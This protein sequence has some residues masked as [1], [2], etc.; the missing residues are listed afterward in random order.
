M[1]KRSWGPAAPVAT[2]APGH[3]V[4]FIAR[5]RQLGALRERGLRVESPLGDVHLREVTATDDPAA[6]DQVDL[7]LFGVK[8]WDTDAGARLVVPLLR[9]DTA[10]GCPS[11]TV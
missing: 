3:D 10:V 7:V 11:I 5:G 6:P 9:K 8:L 4:E 1:R 2:S